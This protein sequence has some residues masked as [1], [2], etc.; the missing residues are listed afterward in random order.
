MLS[1]VLRNYSRK[2][3]VAIDEAINA[4]LNT[5]I[6]QPFKYLREATAQ[7]R[8]AELIRNRLSL[9][10]LPSEVPVTVT[11]DPPAP[12]RFVHAVDQHTSRV[13]LEMKI[14]GC[15]CANPHGK[16]DIVLLRDVGP[17]SLT[18]HAFGPGD[19]ISSIMPNDVHAAIEVKACPSSMGGERAKCIADVEKLFSLIASHPHISSHLIFLDK[20]LAIP[21]IA[22]L[23]PTWTPMHHEWTDFLGARISD[24]QP[25]PGVPYVTIWDIDP[26]GPLRPRRRF[27]L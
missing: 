22:D 16:T 10:N 5:Y 3:N 2:R 20:S 11:L 6:E 9:E 25:A 26:I 15:A 21:N 23:H 8:L 27:Y 4:L 12:P 14:R 7:A 1:L 13:Q 18:C 19:I 24:E 17:V